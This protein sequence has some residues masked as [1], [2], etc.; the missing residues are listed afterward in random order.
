M[1]FDSDIIMAQKVSFCKSNNWAE[2]N[3]GQARRD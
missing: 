3:K 1:A 2:T